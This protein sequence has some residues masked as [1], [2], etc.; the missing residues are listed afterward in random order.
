MQ[1]RRQVLVE[2]TPKGEELLTKLASH[3]QQ[4]LQTFAPDLLS[5]ITALLATEIYPSDIQSQDGANTSASAIQL[6]ASSL[7]SL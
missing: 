7:G 2:L 6:D 3:H 1:D 5:H 4:E